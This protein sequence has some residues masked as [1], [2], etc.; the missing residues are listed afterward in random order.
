LREGAIRE[1]L[2]WARWPI[3]GLGVVLCA[4][5]AIYLSGYFSVV[6]APLAEV[7]AIAIATS[8]GALLLFRSPLLAA[9]AGV[10]VLAAALL[11][12]GVLAP[13]AIAE[14]A[15]CGVLIPHAIAATLL[16]GAGITL[17]AMSGFSAG[18][19]AGNGSDAAAW[20]AVSRIIG[21]ASVALAAVV[22]FR[23]VL[24]LPDDVLR[25]A[26]AVHA[27]DT[28]VVAALIT[29]FVIALAN[30]VFLPLA[31]GTFRQSEGFIAASNRARENRDRFVQELSIFAAPPWALS[32]CGIAVLL[33]V[34]VAF[35]TPRGPSPILRLWHAQ[36]LLFPLS[37]LIAGIAG[38]VGT[39]D[40]RTLISCG[41]APAIA[42][43]LAALLTHRLGTVSGIA[44]GNIAFIPGVSG[45]G[46]LSIAT[47]TAAGLCVLVAMRLAAYRAFD[48]A[49]T[50]A[51]SRTLSE[52]AV[53]VIAL[54][55]VLAAALA[56]LGLWPFPLA[57]MLAA[58]ILTPAL[59]AA[60][61]IILPKLK[62]VEQLYG[63]KAEPR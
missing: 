29:A 36:G 57:A 48:D 31:L 12:L 43:T 15:L 17:F 53:P 11:C 16:S 42:S 22:F 51:W 61:E 58:L 49:L 10:C 40:W 28:S 63:P 2:I 18:V 23:L 8:A 52:V 45:V 59:T 62:S 5:S 44:A 7:T 26:H 6:A 41:L 50:V 27:T 35:G 37:I 1:I 14:P 3:L 9:L 20:A 46:T 34:L 56:P 60:V 47:V 32:I 30:F 39:R 38:I 13:I 25:L 21:P 24:L 54:S 4:A 33:A 55:T 19:C